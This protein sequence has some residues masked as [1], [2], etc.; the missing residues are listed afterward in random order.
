[1]LNRIKTAIFLWILLAIPFYG[2]LVFTEFSAKQN[3][4]KCIDTFLVSESKN[5]IS[6]FPDRFLF[7]FDLIKKS[8]SD[9]DPDKIEDREYLLEKID[10]FLNDNKDFCQVRLADDNGSILATSDEKE[11]GDFVQDSSFSNAVKGKCVYSF[12]Q[13]PKNLKEPLLKFLICIKLKNSKNILIEVVSQW[14]QYEKYIS[15]V[16]SGV[17]PRFLY[18]VSPSFQRYIS[19]KT[20]IP[21]E[22]DVQT[23]GNDHTKSSIALGLYLTKELTKYFDNGKIK[24]FIGIKNIKIHN[25]K[26]TTE[27]RSVI[28]PIN[29]GDKFFGPQMFALNVCKLDQAISEIHH[30]LNSYGNELGMIMLIALMA[31]LLLIS[32][33]YHR[34]KDESELAHSITESTPVPLVIFKCESGEIMRANPPC[35]TLFT[36]GVEELI[37]F[38]AWEF[39]VRKDDVSY[40]SSAIGSGVHIRDYEMMMKTKDGATFW[41]IVSGS[42]IVIEDVLHIVLGVQDITQRKEFEK[43]LA[44]NAEILEKQV[45]ERT[46]DVVQKAEELEESYIELEKAKQ[47][48]EAAN[49]SKSRFL[50]TVS[51]ELIT[52][53]NAITGY[54]KILEEE[55]LERKDSVSAGDLRKI[56]GAANYLLAIIQDILDLSKV[57]EGKI[58]LDFY[59]FAIK[60]IIHDIDGVVRPLIVEQDNTM[61]IEYPEDIGDM[62]SDSTK[63][64]QCILN[65]IS[66]AA[67][68]TELGQITLSCRELYIGGESFIEFAVEDTGVGV[69]AEDIKRILRPLDEKEEQAELNELEQEIS[70]SV[71]D[72]NEAFRKN[73]SEKKGAGLGLI[74]TRRFC[75]FLGGE[76]LIDSELEKG[77]KFMLRF[78]RNANI[79]NHP[80]VEMKN[81]NDVLQKDFFEKNKNK[82]DKLVSSIKKHKDKTVELSIEDVMKAQNQERKDMEEEELMF[83][84]EE[85]FTDEIAKEELE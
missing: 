25:N 13:N 41:A 4:I 34:V 24:D 22:A 31:A 30:M 69:T 54:S 67:K 65:L 18:I 20:G 35:E 21:I 78:P 10:D 28:F 32:I 56:T 14:N 48:A 6:N 43:K 37:G 52:P 38:S 8:W 36:V 11:Y 58:L 59:T 16:T 49:E 60:D 7:T 44:N 63:I 3:A 66:N 84:D 17:A 47:C 50:T 1:M 75:E 71:N 73:V 51:N 46:K 15:S 74:T 23:G 85:D 5:V 81:K 72:Q 80:S 64:R 29:L 57:E 12:L 82:T 83:E 62:Y 45:Q 42:S 39:F 27:F 61:F 70:N 26:K 33:I 79:P 2:W 19:L 9:I 53:I 77:S 55:A 76:L 40:F 68:F